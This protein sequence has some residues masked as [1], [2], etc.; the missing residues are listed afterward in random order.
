MAE[1]FVATQQELVQVTHDIF[2]YNDG[3]QYGDCIGATSIEVNCNVQ[4]MFVCIWVVFSR[5]LLGDDYV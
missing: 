3:I 5:K 2:F 4:H 1:L